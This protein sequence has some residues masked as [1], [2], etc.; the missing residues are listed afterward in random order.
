VLSEEQCDKLL[1]DYKVFLVSNMHSVHSWVKLY[2][3]ALIMIIMYVLLTVIATS[4]LMQ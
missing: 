4:I 1:D 3:V 2:S